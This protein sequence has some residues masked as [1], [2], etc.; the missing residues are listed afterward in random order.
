VA[1]ENTTNGETGSWRV[2]N[3]T[4]SPRLPIEIERDTGVDRG[5]RITVTAKAATNN[6]FPW[7]GGSGE[8]G[9]TQPGRPLGPCRLDSPA[10]AA[11]CARCGARQCWRRANLAS[12]AASQT[13]AR[14]DGAARGA[15]GAHHLGA[16]STANARYV[17]SDAV[18]SWQDGNGNA[19][20][21]RALFARCST[22]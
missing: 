7:Q 15:D 14:A 10:R 18:S 16:A 12:A 21:P 19:L 6:P 4:D 2:G 1:E 5:E 20:L 22:T 8:G 9:P 11:W 17:R 13:R 3:R